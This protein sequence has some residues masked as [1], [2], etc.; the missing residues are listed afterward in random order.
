[1]KQ[2]NK[3][4]EFRQAVYDHGLTLTKDAQFELVDALLLNPGCPGYFSHPPNLAGK[5]G[6]C[7]LGLGLCQRQHRRLATDTD[8]NNLT[9]DGFPQSDQASQGS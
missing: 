9:K 4:I 7:G 1:M 2:F 5:I 3:I 8:A 6:V